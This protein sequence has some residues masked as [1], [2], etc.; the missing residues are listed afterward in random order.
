M[1]PAAASPNASQRAGVGD[2]GAVIMD[3]VVKLFDQGGGFV[4]R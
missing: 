1:V 4:I 3:G 2:N